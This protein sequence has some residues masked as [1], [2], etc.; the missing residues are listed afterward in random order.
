[1]PKTK[2]AKSDGLGPLEI[3]K[4][5]SAIRQVWHRSYARLLC[6][7]RCI[8]KDGFSYC[9]KCSKKAPK[10][11]IDHI[12]AVGDVDG[13]FLERLFCPSEKLQGL[14]KKCHDEKTKL[15]RKAKPKQGKIK[16]KVESI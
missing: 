4:I 5:R 10:V 11:Y 6:A 12:V 16:V 3:R 1:M 9:E 8:G 7:K 2:I 13:G 14:C 15:E